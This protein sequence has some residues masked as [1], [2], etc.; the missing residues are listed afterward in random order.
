MYKDIERNILLYL[1]TMFKM[2]M[3]KDK[4]ITILGGQEWTCCEVS[5]EHKV[6]RDVTA[7]QFNVTQLLANL[8]VPS[9]YRSM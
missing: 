2:D 1:H 8:C 5:R 7:S 9:L 3:Y 4:R 6:G